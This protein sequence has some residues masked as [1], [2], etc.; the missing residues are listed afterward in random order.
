VSV[1]VLG[2]EKRGSKTSMIAMPA[3][4]DKACNFVVPS[5]IP[6]DDRKLF[7]FMFDM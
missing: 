3:S 1:M 6:S 5:K 4:S 2:G 7:E